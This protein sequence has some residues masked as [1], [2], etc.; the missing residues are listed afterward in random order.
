MGPVI[1]AIIWDFVL[2][3]DESVNLT[4]LS[5][6]IIVAILDETLP[7]NVNMSDFAIDTPLSWEEQRNRVIEAVNK[8][9]GECK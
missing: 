9:R 5:P 1:K 2:S 6:D 3:V 7:E 8:V 4:G